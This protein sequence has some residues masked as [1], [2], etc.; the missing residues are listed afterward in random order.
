MNVLVAL[1]VGDDLARSRD[2]K[3]VNDGSIKWSGEII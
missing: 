3:S 2:Y 1:I